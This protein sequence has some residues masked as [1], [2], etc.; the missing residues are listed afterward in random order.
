MSS[1]K[2]KQEENNELELKD[3]NLNNESDNDIENKKAEKKPWLVRQTE[4]K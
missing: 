4:I 3:E 1:K 2:K